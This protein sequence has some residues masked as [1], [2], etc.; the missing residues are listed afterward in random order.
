MALKSWKVSTDKICIRSNSNLLDGIGMDSQINSEQITK[1][2]HQFPMAREKIP[3]GSP[4]GKMGPNCKTK[5]NGRLGHQ[6]HFFF[7]KIFGSKNR[8]ETHLKSEP[9]DRSHHPQIHFTN[10]NSRLD[11]G[12]GY[13]KT[14][15]WIHYLESLMQSLLTYFRRSGLEDRG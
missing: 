13:H 7:C 15:K 5:I 10:P 11:H 1:N 8:L 12:F 3:K 4:L 6:K 2:L 9:I 14:S